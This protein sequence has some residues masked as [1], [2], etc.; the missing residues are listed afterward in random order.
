MKN[1]FNDVFNDKTILITGHTGFIGSWL[2]I[3]LNELGSKVIGYALEPY[4][5]EDNFVVSRL[6][7]KIIDI[8]GDVRNYKELLQ[9]FKKYKPEFVFHLAAQPLVRLSYKRPKDTYD[10]NVGGTVNLLESA[11]N[12]N[13]VRVIIN[14]TSD[15][16][17]ENKEWVWGYRENDSIGGYDPYSSSKG[18][19]ELITAAYRNSYFNP[20][21][22]IRHNKTIVSVRAGNVIG[23]G[24]WGKYRIVPDCIRSLQKKKKILVRNPYSIRP[25]QHVLEPISGCLLLASEM[26]RNGFNYSDAWNF[27]PEPNS[28]IRVKDLVERL[29]KIWGE[30]DWVDSS[31]LKDDK[32][33]TNLLSLDISKAKNFLKWGPTLDINQCLEF[34]VDWYKSRDKSYKFSVKQIEKFITIHEMKK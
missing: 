17:Y 11:R 31:D 14:V 8:R 34:T 24:D 18:C 33:E 13:S 23:G 9:V 29:I 21:D 26:Y 15:K 32:H 19:C 10:I 2:S 12:T 20:S 28:I 1:L 3:W 25:W 30:G 16:C 5:R 7:E 6:D 22:Y 27:G 4:T